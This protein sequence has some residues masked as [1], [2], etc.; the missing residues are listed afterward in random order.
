MICNFLSVCYL[1]LFEIQCAQNE[2]ECLTVFARES[3]L[4]SSHPCKC[5]AEFS[6]EF[7]YPEG[8]LGKIM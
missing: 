3:M 6:D 7:V 8:S 5:M 1:L 2:T 4:L